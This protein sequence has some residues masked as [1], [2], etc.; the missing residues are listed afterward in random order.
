MK[1][2]VVGMG[3][4]GLSMARHLL[5]LGAT[6]SAVDNRP[7]PPLAKAFSDLLGGRARFGENFAAWQERHFAD[8]DLVAKSPGVALRSVAAAGRDKITGDAALFTAAWRQAP[9]PSCRL[10]AVT[11][12]NGKSTVV[13]LARDLCV[14]AGLRA[15]AVG[16]IGEPLLDAWARWQANSAPAVAVAELSSF[17]LETATEFCA[18]AA[19][20]LNIAPDHL[21]RHGSLAGY[22]AAKGVIYRGAKHRVVNADDVL[23]A[24]FAPPPHITFSAQQKADWRLTE[25]TIEGDASFARADFSPTAEPE[26]ALAALA[27]TSFLSLSAAARAQALTSF[28]GLPHR[29]QL[30]MRRGG[31]RFID[32]SKAT[33]VASACFALR[34]EEQVALIAG[35]DGKGQD[36]LPLAAAAQGRTR[37]AVLLGKD[38]PLLRTAFDAIGVPTRCADNMR[39][40]VSMAAAGAQQGEAI[41]LS[42]A[43]SSLDMY[44][45]YEARGDDFAAACHAWAEGK[46]YA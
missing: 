23:A 34:R 2:L 31:T 36:F 24:S 17:Q 45:N 38:A 25:Q 33:N 22:A 9:P 44:K 7:Q 46:N 1:A 27:L 4:T 30:I 14:A 20:I 3:M 5:A 13:R 29:R 42:P 41:L 6:V 12:T 21:D 37:V 15:E 35:G 32:D 26:N 43:C 19:V 16:N 11:G 40:A 18:D 8:Y 10:L 39:Q 28:V